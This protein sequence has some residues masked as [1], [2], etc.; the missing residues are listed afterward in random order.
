MGVCPVSGLVKIMKNKLFI[1]VLLMF[2]FAKAMV[3]FVPI[4]DPVY[5]YLE[6][7]ATRGYIPEFMNDTRPLLR[8]DIAKQLLK[9]EKYVAELPR[10][11]REML[12][13]Y[14]SEYRHELT[15]LRHP[16]ISEGNDYRLGIASFG[17]FKEDLRHVFRDD[18]SEER[19][20]IYTYEDGKTTVWVGSDF[21]ARAESKGLHVRTVDKLGGQAF[22][23]AGEHL[24][25]YADAYF[26]HQIMNDQ[27]PG[28]VKEYKGYWLNEHE[29]D[30]IATFDCSEAY[31]NLSGNF[32]T[33]S[34]AHH[35]VSWGNAMN[36]VILSENAITFGSLRWMKQFRHFKYSFLHG[37]LMTPTFARMDDDGRYFIPKYLVAHRLEI[38]LSP[39]I[40]VNFSEMIT[41][42]G[43]DRIPELTY[44]VPLIFL[45][46]SEHALGDRD[47]KMIALEAEVFPLNGLRLF[48]TVFLDELVFGQIFN[49]FWANKYALQGGFQISPR[50][51]PADLVVE[52]TA[53]HPWT[54]THRFVYGNYT[55]HGR[56]LGFFAGPN[57]RQLAA[58]LNYDL[59]GKHKL[60]LGYTHLQKGADSILVNDVM[61][62]IGGDSNQNDYKRSYALDHATSWL[63]GDV[64]NTHSL[65]LEWLYRWRNHIHFLSG[66]EY[67]NVQN[68]AHMYYSFQINFTY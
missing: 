67:R 59:S 12:R 36:S 50:R 31:A 30:R 25:F 56:D 46:P 48:G 40:H 20:H 4:Q 61:Y 19:R 38:H 51:I 58:K 23:Q 37:S 32:G 6:R 68:E 11:D 2:S 10:V 57:S 17:N 13:D 14:M 60:I 33:L 53:V 22:I 52:A 1:L 41:Y 66:C 5:D 3:L 44:L 39:R 21:M 42:G 54:Y 65:R 28:T 27:Y 18:L 34:I 49:D 24:A 63:M 55:H 8:D 29:F 35:P 15:E 16:V 43:E 45:W 62:P 9:M 7:M 47:N 26:F 64:M